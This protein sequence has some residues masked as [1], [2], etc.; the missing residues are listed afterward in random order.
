MKVVELV[1]EH[2]LSI[3]MSAKPGETETAAPQTQPDAR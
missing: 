1:V 3:R 2:K